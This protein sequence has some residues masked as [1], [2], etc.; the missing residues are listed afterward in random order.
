MLAALTFAPNRTS[1]AIIEILPRKN[2][3]IRKTLAL[4]CVAHLASGLLFASPMPIVNISASNARLF[5]TFFRL[6]F[7]TSATISLASPDS[8]GNATKYRRNGLDLEAAYCL[9]LTV[10]LVWSESA[11]VKLGRHAADFSGGPA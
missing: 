11:T 7:A 1:A 6:T 4:V 8:A 2:L 5:L 9:F 10:S 3:F